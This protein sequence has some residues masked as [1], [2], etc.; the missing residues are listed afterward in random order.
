MSETGNEQRVST[1]KGA[2]DTVTGGTSGVADAGAG[3]G[4][5]G[6]LFK[7]VSNRVP[8]VRADRRL[9]FAGGGAFVALVAAGLGIRWWRRRR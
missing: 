9:A 5:G 4:S 2:D 3:S 6:S 7:R 8:N 1:P